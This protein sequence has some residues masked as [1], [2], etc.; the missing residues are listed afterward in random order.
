MGRNTRR[1][2]CRS[3]MRPTVNWVAAPHSVTM[4][5]ATPISGSNAA[6]VATRS[7]ISFGISRVKAL[8][9]RPETTAISSSTMIAR[10]TRAG[11]MGGNGRVPARA[12]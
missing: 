3:I 6:S 8:N 12:A 5:A 9:T 2:V 4:N 1:S 10:R 7:W 11:G